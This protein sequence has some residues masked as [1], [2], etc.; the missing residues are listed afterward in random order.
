[1]TKV[2]LNLSP[3]TCQWLSILHRGGT[4]GYWWTA[5][6]KY[7]EWWESGEPTEVP[8]GEVNTYVGVH[9]TNRSRGRHE[10]ARISDIVAVNCLF[11]EFDAKDFGNKAA[12]LAHINTLPLQP[13]IIVDS[14]GGYHCYWLLRDTFVIATEPDRERI[15]RLQAAWVMSVGGDEGAKD[16]ARVLRVPGTR[17][18][19]PQYAPDFPVVTFVRTDFER[20]YTLDE[21]ER[22]VSFEPP[23]RARSV[24]RPPQIATGTAMATGTIHTR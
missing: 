7:S 10:R 24:P 8:Q 16:L 2:T 20:V 9:P 13:P 17:N 15:R 21:L 14:G 19:K 3:E 5:E 6:G 11:A 18:Y 22:L 23:A 1:M 4:C 12:A